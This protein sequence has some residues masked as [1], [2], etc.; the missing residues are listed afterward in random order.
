MLRAIVCVAQ[1]RLPGPSDAWAR[2]LEDVL[3]H[4]QRAIFLEDRR[5]ALLVLGFI[6]STKHVVPVI[7]TPRGACD[8]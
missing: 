3:R 5:L 4:G 2:Q 8:P 1:C 7:V 6:I